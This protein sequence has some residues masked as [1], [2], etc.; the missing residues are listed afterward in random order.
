MERLQKFLSRAGVTSRRKAEVLIARGRV[1]VNGETVYRLGT[2]VS[3][4][5]DR[6]SLDGKRIP[7][8]PS[9]AWVYLAFH[10]PRGVITT[11]RDPQGRKTVLRYF[12]P[13]TRVYPVGRLDRDSE[14]LLLVT[15]DGNFAQ[16]LTHPRYHVEKEYEVMVLG[17]MTQ[18]DLIA[19]ER[20]VPLDGGR[21]TAKIQSVRQQ[22]E[23]TALRL[24]LEEGRK[25]QIRRM[26]ALLGKEVIRL[27]R[28]RIG[29]VPLAPLKPGELRPLTPLE[30]KRL[31]A[32]D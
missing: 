17:E 3:P 15:N 4:E 1:Q 2:S 29:P 32:H 27:K 18:K 22:G 10:K 12:P 20:G 7:P 23:R 8:P 28:V 31:K 11:L 25:R 5:K 6:V 9:D 21:R 13:K 16:R 24:I 30:V 14:G 19:L 26:L